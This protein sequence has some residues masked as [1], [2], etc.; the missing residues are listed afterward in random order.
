MNYESQCVFEA[1]VH[2]YL[3]TTQDSS[4]E[5]FLLNLIIAPEKKFPFNKLSFIV[6]QDFIVKYENEIKEIYNQEKMSFSEYFL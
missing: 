2:G 5:D 1:L 3:L 6:S 4:F